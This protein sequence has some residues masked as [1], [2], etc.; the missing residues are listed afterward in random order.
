MVPEGSLVVLVAAFVVC[1]AILMARKRNSMVLVCSS[2]VPDVNSVVSG[3]S[4]M[5]PVSSSV[6]N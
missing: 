6:A 5:A 2:V 4:T 3:P 1:D